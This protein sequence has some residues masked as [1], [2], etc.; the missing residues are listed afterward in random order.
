MNLNLVL[1]FSDILQLF[2]CDAAYDRWENG[3]SYRFNS[4]NFAFCAAYNRD[5]QQI[6]SSLSRNKKCPTRRCSYSTSA[7]SLKFNEILSNF[8]KFYVSH[9]LFWNS[10][11]QFIG[12]C[13]Q[14][15]NI[16]HFIVKY[17]FKT[18]GITEN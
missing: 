2:R 7:A 13:I 14:N 10:I 4:G 6:W 12:K 11:L 8:I 17:S 9:R 3:R 18:L 1:V 16:Y 15:I 5:R